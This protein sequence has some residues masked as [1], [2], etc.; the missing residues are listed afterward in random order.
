M[1]HPKAARSLKKLPPAVS[2]RIVA[3]LRELE[4]A[5]DKGE[6]LSDSQF[7]RV[8]VGDYR[9]I[10]EVDGRAKRVIVLYVGHRSTV[11]DDFSKL[12]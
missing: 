3:S 7:I 11:Y 10:Y 2:K 4:A 8:R 1:L 9:A 5:P 6:R 12:L